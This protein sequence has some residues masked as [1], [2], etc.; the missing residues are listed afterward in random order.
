MTESGM[1][2]SIESKLKADLQPSVLLVENES[3]MHGGSATESH[4]RVTV[5]SEGFVPMTRVQRHQQVYKLLAAELA[6]GVHA[7]GLHLY[8]VP[9][10]EENNKTAPLSPDC[11]GGSKSEV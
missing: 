8:T 11:R 10:W 9:E 7:L 1:Q 5:V 6:Q 2:A 4:Y 3:H